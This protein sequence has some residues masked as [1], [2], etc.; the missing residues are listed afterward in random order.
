MEVVAT[1]L[2][3]PTVVVVVSVVGRG[4]EH[5]PRTRRS[6]RWPWSGGCSGGSRLCGAR[7][8]GKSIVTERSLA[9]RSLSGSW[10]CVRVHACACACVWVC[11]RVHVRSWVRMYSDTR[12]GT[13]EVLP[14]RRVGERGD[15]TARPRP[16]TSRIIPSR[17]FSTL[18]TLLQFHFQ[19]HRSFSIFRLYARLSGNDTVLHD[20]TA[21]APSLAPSGVATFQKLPISTHDFRFLCYVYTRTSYLALLPFGGSFACSVLRLPHSQIPLA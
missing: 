8:W 4:G 13:K 20:V 18:A 14:R 21:C 5:R 2:A 15:G 10:L 17:V 6:E 19:R 7:W 3:L 11:M 1:T 9:V 16:P 12:K